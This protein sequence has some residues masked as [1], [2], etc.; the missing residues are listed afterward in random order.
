MHTTRSPSS[1]PTGVPGDALDLSLSGSPLSMSKRPSS[2]SP[3]KYFSRSVSVSVAGDSR[4]KRNTLSDTSLGSSRSIKN[5]RRSNSTTQV[6]QQANISLSQ[7]QSEDYLALFDSSSDGRKK[8]ASLSKTSPDRTTWNI[9]DDQPRAFPLHSSSRSTGSVDSPTS[10][11]KREPGIALAATFTA[12]NRSNKGAVGNSVTTILHN[13]YSEKPLTPKSS[14]QKPSFNNILK[15]TANDEVS[16]ENGSLTKSQKNFS[17]ASLASNN[18]SPV[19]AQHGSPVLL[20]RREVT[21][22]EAERFIQQVNQAAVTI[23][24]WYRH[25]AKSRHTKQAALKR[26]LASKR[27]EWEE[28]TEEERCLEQQQKKEED[29]KRIREEKARLAR[30]AAIK[31]LQQKRAQRAAEMQH[32]PE[33]ELETLR[34]TVVV[35][36]KKPPKISPINK[37]P[38]SPSNNSPMSPTDIKTKNTDSNLNV[39]ADT[40]DLTFRAISP[41]LSNPRGSRCSQEDQ[42]EEEISLEQHQASDRKLI[43]KD[44]GLLA[45]LTAP[46]VTTSNGLQQKRAQHAAETHA[47]EV[48]LENSRQTSV[49]G[50]KKVPKISPTNKSPASPSNNSPMSPTD[51]KTKNTDSNLNIVAD[52]GE[53]SFRAI[54]P[55]LSNRRG[56]QCSQEILQ[57][58]VSVE[59]QRQGGLSSRAQ[60]KTTLNELLDTLKLLEEEPE[61]LSEPKCY[62]KEKYAWID[63]DGDLNSLTTDNLERHGQLSHHPTLPDG[64]A[65]LSEAKLQSIMSFLD[66]MEKSEQE[67]PRSVTSGSHREA[68]LSEEELAGVE[69]VSATAAE[70]TSSMM[71]IKLELEEK[72]RTI[73]MLQTALAQQRELTIRHVKETEKELSRNFQLQKE[74]YES[75]IQRHLTF[76]D[77]LINDKKALS[78]RC[79]GVVGELKQVDQKYTKKITQMQE[80]HEMVWQILGPLCEEIKKLKDLMSATEKIRREKWIDEKTKK[81]KE[82]TVKGL[83]P[84]IQKLISKHKQELKRLRTLHEAE[85]LQAD[86]RAAQ[87][88]IRQCEELRQ[89]LERDNEEQCQRERELAKQ[90]YEKQLQEEEVSLQQ[91]R[92]RLY[93]EI[94]DEKERLAQLAARQRA[95][96]DDLRRQLEENSS[97]AGRALKEE[98]DKTREEQE[99]RHQVEL[100]ALQERLDIEK[101]AWEENYKKKEEAWLLTRER[102]LKEQLRRERDK[103]IELAIWTL[104]EETSKDKEECERAAENRLKRVR[105]KYEAELR[106]LERS[107]RV[108]VEKQQEVRKQQM[109]TEGELIRLQ[110]MLRQ[111]EQEVEEITQARDKLAEER[112]SLA[113]VIR[114]EF[115]DRLVMTEEENRRLKVEVSEVRARMR[116]EVERVTREKEEEL[117]EVHQRVKSAILKKEETVNN[118]R[119][120]HEAALKRADHL[121]ALWEQQ[122]KQLLEK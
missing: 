89:Q 117:A 4:G 64:G 30:L 73:N 82:I 6:N 69:Q 68:V 47:L 78:E 59:D 107:E 87:R 49:V 65:L 66:E 28:R 12:N 33:V 26:I 43:R 8:L 120:Q 41:T 96:L 83:E 36:R 105:E 67:R 118:L 22:E 114:Q 56:S 31:E 98:L 62:H 23:Q 85:L 13:N 24:R 75:T 113:E 17:S 2:A 11:K 50:R 34:Q 42:A 18:K 27:K 100:K 110:A 93:K 109:E 116:L 21:E 53:L 52:L 10:L 79:E 84:E 111:K 35:G 74:Q 71:R 63:E 81:I 16:L 61:R 94:A 102:E 91:Q 60:S 104:E 119:K 108:A 88:Y 20:R 38:A 106:D 51:V 44:G 14:N 5:L 121:E 80:Q 72:K 55:A 7:G 58:S 112:R 25:H 39:V 40:G 76:I 46:Q 48:E 90:R 9:L 86:D 101:Q 3:G 77:Q 32:M 57:R 29:R 99:R 115:A 70:V 19:S 37:S 103:E 122:R 45:C 97:L 54:S 1:I 92:R 15:A 95:E